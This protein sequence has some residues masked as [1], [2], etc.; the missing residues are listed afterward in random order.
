MNHC[1]EAPSV[2]AESV[3]GLT[4]SL[5]PVCLDRIPAK[6]VRRGDD[7]YLRKTCGKH[8]DFSAILW[9]GKPDYASWL[10]KKEVR[11]PEK[12]LT[13]VDKGCPFDC[14]LC[15]EHGQRICFA[16]FEITGRCNLRCPVCF[17]DSG[18][19]ES[20]DPSMEE[21]VGQMKMIWDDFG[22]CNI[23]LSGGEPTMREDLPEIIRA[24][25]SLGYTFVQLNTN[26]IRLAEEP[27]FAYSLKKA[28]LSTVFLQFD[29]TRDE[30]Y[31]RLRGRD[32][33]A[34]KEKAIE[35]CGRSR[36]GVVLVPT[37]APGVNTGDIGAIVHYALRGMPAIRGIHFQPISYFGRYPSPPR[38]EDRITLPEVLAAL[39]RQTRGL[40]RVD[41]FTHADCEHSLCSFHGD[42]IQLEEGKLI[43][44]TSPKNGCC[45][46]GGPNRDVVR[47]AQDYIAHRWQMLDSA[48]CRANSEP[49]A[50]DEFDRLLAKALNN[51]LSITCM[52]FQDV[53]N[54]DLE[55]LKYCCVPVIRG[56]KAIP[57]C[58]YNLSNRDGSPLHRNVAVI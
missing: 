34:I 52:T 2:S 45:G 41:N 17:A 18:G 1:L 49:A 51:R 27:E 35:N 21:I 23:Q 33:F 14:G 46:A 4:H 29:G 42:F 26:G 16:Q 13:A 19:A 24:A 38:D 48:G 28:G 32:L 40:V 39:E 47:Q 55:R 25:R 50:G 44:Y 11:P 7:V 31:R 9:R 5:C 36:L 58:A 15:P 12:S 22:K 10:K 56:G 20:R 3:I 6:T 53:E 37:L 57:F 54:I 30:I 43:P 8:G